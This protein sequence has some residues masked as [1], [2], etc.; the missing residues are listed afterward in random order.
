M[1]PSAVNQLTTILPTASKTSSD[2]AGRKEGG[3]EQ[4]L[5]QATAV[6]VS[7]STLVTLEVAGVGFLAILYEMLSFA[8]PSRTRLFECG[9]L[10]VIHFFI[11]LV[12]VNCTLVAV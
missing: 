3:H 4:M 10:V 8:S 9:L 2:G 5:G 12:V 1:F 7:L 6:L 11:V